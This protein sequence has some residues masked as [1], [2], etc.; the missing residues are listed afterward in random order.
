ML[1]YHAFPRAE[2]VSLFSLFCFVTCLY[3]FIPKF[4]VNF[5]LIYYNIPSFIKIDSL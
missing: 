1:G 3:L 4:I 5:K 2:S